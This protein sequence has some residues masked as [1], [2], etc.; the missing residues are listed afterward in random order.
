[1]TAKLFEDWLENCFVHDVRNY[2]RDLNLSFKVLLLVDNAPGHP[3]T[4]AERH[5]DIE[6]LFLPPKHYINPPTHGSRCHS[7]IQNVLNQE[8]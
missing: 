7:Y 6:F 2:L 1:M 5:P 4:L 8:L 3:A